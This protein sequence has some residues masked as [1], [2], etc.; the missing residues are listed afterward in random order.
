MTTHDTTE[1]TETATGPSEERVDWQTK[2]RYFLNSDFVRSSPYWG[3]PF[4]LMGIAVYGGIGYNL[5]ISFTDYAGIARPSF[6]SLDLEMYRRALADGSF[7]AA[8]FQ[9]FVLLVGFTSISLGLGLFLAVLLDYGIRYKET[10]QTIYLLPM[11]L[12]FVVTA[13]LWLWM[14]S[15]GSNGMLNVLVTTFGFEPIDW[16]GNPKLSLAA[17]IFAL[18]WQFSGYAMV[19]FL[20]GLQS[21]PSDQFEAAKVDGASTTKTYVRII[22]P[23]LKQASVGAAVV[24]MLFALKAFDFL[25]AITGNYRPPNGTD[26]LATL[27]VREAF[28]YGQWAYGA[29]IATMLLLLSLAVIAPYLIFQH[30]Q[31]SL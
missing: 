6:S 22:I 24:L 1:T 25:Y 30:R 17:V 31:G 7:R 26:I 20:A 5:A 28:Q 3:I 14:Y 18:V 19:V 23:Q 8:A 27:M 10:I 21:L 12:S 11:A 2:L 9:N 29:A 13:Q 16:L 15:P 4:L